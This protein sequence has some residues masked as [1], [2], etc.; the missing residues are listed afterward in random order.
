LSVGKK[1]NTQI[2]YLENKNK[3]SRNTEN[4]YLENTENNISRKKEIINYY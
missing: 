2:K 4:K 3:I 1:K